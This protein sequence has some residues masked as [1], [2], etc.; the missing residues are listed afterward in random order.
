M[1]GE[2]STSTGIY[3]VTVYLQKSG[4]EFEIKSMEIDK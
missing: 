3:R 2:L 1:I 4:E